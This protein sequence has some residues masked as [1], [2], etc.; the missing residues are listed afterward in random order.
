MFTPILALNPVK[1]LPSALSLLSMDCNMSISTMSSLTPISDTPSP[2]LSTGSS[3]SAL[4]RIR[5]EPDPLDPDSNICLANVTTDDRQGISHFFGRNKKPTASI[6]DNMF[7]VLC[8]THYQEKQYRWREDPAA[9]AAFQCD[10]IL[11][12]LERMC[13]RTFVDANGISWPYWCGFELQA[14]RPGSARPCRAD[15]ALSSHNS[16]DEP[17][18]PTWLLPLC[19]NSSTHDP[20]PNTSFTAIGERQPIRYTFSQLT[21]I[22]KSIKTYV[23]AHGTK[24]P[25]V[26]ALPVTIGMVDEANLEEAKKKL[27]AATRELTVAQM[28]LTRH[29]QL[30]HTG[31]NNRAGRA[32]D[33]QLKAELR[34]K[35]EAVRDAQTRVSEAE[36]DAAAT[37]ETV[38]TKRLTRRHKPST[39]GNTKK[40]LPS[41]PPRPAA[42]DH[43]KSP[44]VGLSPHSRAPEVEPITDDEEA[45]NAE[46]DGKQ[47]GDSEAPLELQTSSPVNRRFVITLRY[48]QGV[49]R[50]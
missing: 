29:T 20:P 33:L 41:I 19:T 39:T 23:L 14:Q 32:R 8:R 49:K 15:S 42:H 2:L 50:A 13:H 24:L 22:V 30:A 34:L 28:E 25:S 12:T 46:I 44:S 9:F 27:K 47:D 21:L 17:A 1:F 10:C 6:P 11:K 48:S 3:I 43:D 38:P 35:E 18:V 45:A 26:E 36:K 37:K 16:E 5:C 7:P 4:E 40:Q 31:L